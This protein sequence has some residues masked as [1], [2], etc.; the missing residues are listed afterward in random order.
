MLL[1]AAKQWK[2]PAGQ[3]L[4]DYR[5]LLTAIARRWTSDTMTGLIN[6]LQ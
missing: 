5:E 2:K 1:N 6:S 4:Q 3:E